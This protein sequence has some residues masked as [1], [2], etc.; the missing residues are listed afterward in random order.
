[1]SMSTQPKTCRFASAT[2]RLPGPTILSTAPDRL[3]PVGE[4]PHRL[5]A[6]DAV[7]LVHAGDVGRGENRGLDQLAAGA[8]VTITTSSTP[9]TRAGI[10]F[11][12]TD[13]G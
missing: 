2:Q 6:A 5:R 10:T 4:R 7:D 13:D 12:S 11:I 3:R 9:A 8:G 1:M